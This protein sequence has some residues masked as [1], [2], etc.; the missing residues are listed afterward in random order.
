MGVLESARA[1]LDAQARLLDRRIFQAVFEDAS[2][3]HVGDVLLGFR[4]ADGGFGFALEPDLRTPTSQPIFVEVAFQAL[5][6]SGARDEALIEEACNWLEG[7]ANANGAV[8]PVLADALEYP[9]AAHWN[10]D[11]AVTPSLNPTAA[12][13]GYLHKWGF[14]HPW[15][16]EATRWCVRSIQEHR[17]ESAHTLRCAF[18]LAEQLGDERLWD[19]LASQ[20]DDAE[21]FQRAVP[22]TTYCLTPLHFPRRLF[23]RATIDA[24]LD[25]L[26]ARQEDD[27]GWPV[28]WEPPGPAAK[29][30]WRGRWTLDALLALR[31]HGRI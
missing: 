20:L 1:F 14:D 17:I 5:D 24:H 11:W 10:G 25:D 27:G 21:W 23:D 9:R 26:L 6:E 4:N 7:V 13:A 30:E 8:A 16:D 18:R 3:H 2:P 22:V 19:R 12:I 15:R 28:L 31:A 29:A